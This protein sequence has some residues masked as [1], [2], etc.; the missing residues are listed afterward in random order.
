MKKFCISFLG[1]LIITLSF[2][3]IFLNTGSTVETEYLRLHV[4]ANSNLMVDQQVKYKVKDAVVQFLT[5]VVAECTTR[6]KAELLLNQN[7]DGIERVTDAVLEANG[8]NY[9]SKATIREEEF[10]LRKYGDL[11]LEEGVY[12]ALIIELGSGEGNNW[13]CVVYPPLCFT[14]DGVGYRY[15]SKILEIINDFRK[16]R[17]KQ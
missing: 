6:E 1:I 16:E 13:W 14:G 17:E 9:K 12:K 7:L 10:P 8:F 2:I 4:R 15:K 5:P 11:T 3:G